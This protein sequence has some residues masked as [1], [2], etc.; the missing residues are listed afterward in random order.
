MEKLYRNCFTQILKQCY[1]RSGSEKAF[2]SLEKDGSW[3]D[4]DYAAQNRSF[5]HCS[6]HLIRLRYMAAQ[7]SNPKDV[8][9]HS[10]CLGEALLQALT[11]WTKE[12]RYAENWWW[13]EIFVPVKL[14]EICILAKELI[15]HTT[16]FQA[17]LPYLRQTKLG[18]S[19][20]NRIWQAQGMLFTAILTEDEKLLKRAHKEILAEIVYGKTEGIRAD[21][22][23]HQ[24]GPQLQF[25]NYGLSYLESM[26]F[27]LVCFAGTKWQF[28]KITP[29][30][31]FV[32]NGLKWVLWKEVMDLTA[33]GRQIQ[34]DTQT[35]K[36][37]ICRAA[38]AKLAKA[39]PFFASR[40]KKEVTGNTMFFCSDYMVH[41]TRNFY[42]SFRA[43]SIHTLAVETYVNDDNL[44]GQYLSDGVLMVM[45]TGREYLNIA[46][47][48][49]WTRLPGTTLP[50]T[51]RYTK[52]ES[53]QHGFFSTSGEAPEVTHSVARRLY[54][55]SRF[56]GGVS[57][58]KKYGAMI[59]CMDLD[60]LK[61]KKA[62]FFAGNRII[63]LGCSIDS[64]SPYFVATTVEQ[65]LL[66]G[67]VEK[68]DEWFYH[69]GIGYYGKC[70]QLHTETRKGDW[71]P[72][73]GGY[74]KSVPDEKKIFLLT[75]EHGIRPANGS[76]EYA[77][78]PDTT[79]EKM[80]EMVKAYEVLANTEKIQAVR[81]K[82]N[83]VMAVFHQP[84]TLGDFSTNIPGIFILGK[85]KIYAAD[86]SRSKRLLRIKFKKQTFSLSLP[87]GAFAG[88]TT[89]IDLKGDLQRPR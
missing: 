13:N 40:Y 22:S 8:R 31:D 15:F 54:G 24:H 67:K 14:G 29:F 19:G 65:N 28:V 52:E 10:P 16:L 53:I 72:T 69:N 4:I 1:D 61:A 34:K 20:Q 49:S 81:L 9:F 62:V 82:D 2:A 74:G 21:G 30:R 47:C 44:L 80:P 59:Y 17:L 18:Y 71:K 73:W 86:P 88:S 5:W 63:A 66:Q 77:V 79:A 87:K 26:T 6:S 39:D 76:Y 85:K 83:T 43:N 36:N 68:G 3:Q 78:F 38:I 37:K 84:G 50:D 48:W 27:F 58:G 89:V 56:T 51:P 32:C 11:F 75:V 12:R 70:L 64:D 33:Q 57:D 42:A 46:G 60:Q 55:E 35:R 7:W 41:R 45:R 23:F 25:G